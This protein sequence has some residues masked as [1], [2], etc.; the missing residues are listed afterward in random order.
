MTSS[1]TYNF[2]LS[3]G[4][5]VLAAL[6]RVRVRAPSIRQEHFLTARREMNLLLVEWANKQVNLWKVALNTISLVSGTATYSIPA[7]TVL[8]LD[9]YITTNP[10]SQYGQNNRYITQLSRTEYASLSNP[11][12]QGPPTQIW[13]DRLLVPTITFWPV[14]DSN[15]PYTFSYYRAVQIQDVAVAGGQ[16]LNMP[17]L[18]MD[19][20]VSELSWRFAMSYAPQI[21]DKRKMQAQE[22]WTVAASQNIEVV[23]LSLAP[24]IGRYFPR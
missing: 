18:W 1:G 7:T 21:E 3:N 9:A 5:G 15:G 4:E 2:S 11:L 20:Y 17:Y 19:A 6:E 23:N 13:F 22:A 24:P 16:T 14:P 12:T 10:G 8:V